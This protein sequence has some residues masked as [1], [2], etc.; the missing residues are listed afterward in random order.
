M[1]NVTP[2][3]RN[4][5]NPQILQDDRLNSLVADIYD[6]ALDSA[7]WDEV[8]A[9]VVEFVGGIA[10]GIISNSPAG[11]L[12]ESRYRVGMDC[13]FLRRY[14]ETYC[15]LDPVAKICGYEIEE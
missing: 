4:F 15:K 7:Q 5:R 10:G 13:E 1:S 3:M 14:A 2:M 9:R 8:L 6:T 11:A 12:T